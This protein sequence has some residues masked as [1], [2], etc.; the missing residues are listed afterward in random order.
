VT[1]PTYT[2]ADGSA[3]IT[4]TER[5]VF[6]SNGNVVAQTNRAGLPGTTGV[7]KAAPDGYTI[8]GGTTE[9]QTG[10][11]GKSMLGL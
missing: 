1:Y 5:S 9:I 6:D 2:P 4:P 10:I 7:A 11:L 8:L 3:A